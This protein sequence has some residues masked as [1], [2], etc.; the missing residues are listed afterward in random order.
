MDDGGIMIS[1]SSECESLMACELSWQLSCDESQSAHDEA[2]SLD[3]GEGR[4]R[5]VYA[6]AEVCG[7]EAWRIV[8][9]RWHCSERELEE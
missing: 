7:D 4:A 8:R 6:S 5:H 1:L 9:V 2:R 3:L